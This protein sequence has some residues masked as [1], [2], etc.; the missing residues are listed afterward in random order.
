MA[1]FPG[2]PRRLG[3]GGTPPPVT[4]PP[5]TAT[6]SIGTDTFYLL[7]LGFHESVTP[8][9][10]GN[11]PVQITQTQTAVVGANDTFYALGLVLSESSTPSTT[12]GTFQATA[13]GSVG[14]DTYYILG[15]VLSED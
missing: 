3:S 9:G 2:N 7:G 12:A 10:A 8:N 4:T 13:M 11:A 5:V 1:G 15:V 6:A 14:G